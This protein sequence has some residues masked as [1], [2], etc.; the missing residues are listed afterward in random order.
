MAPVPYQP[1]PGNGLAV[2]S[3]VLG[4]LGI[5]ACL[6]P[7]T[8]LPAIVCGFLAIRAKQ[9]AGLA[10]AGLITGLLATLGGLVVLAMLALPYLMGG[11]W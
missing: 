1:A 11:T 2:A 3:L 6:G 4:I 5:A 7:I 9:P 8:G 10:V